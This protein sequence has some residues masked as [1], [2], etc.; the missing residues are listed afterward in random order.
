LYSSIHLQS[1]WG[2]K[3]S[4]MLL[5]NGDVVRWWDRSTARLVD[6]STIVFVFLLLPQILKNAKALAAGN[7]AALA[8]LSWVVRTP[9]IP[10]D[11]FCL[12]VTPLQIPWY[13][14]FDLSSFS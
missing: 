10:Q 12:T 14:V 3:L 2:K 1:A 5:Q 11:R 9:D 6:A 7:A 4:S 8:G 13:T